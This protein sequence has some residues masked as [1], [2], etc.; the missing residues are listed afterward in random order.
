MRE[1]RFY[2][3]DCHVEFKVIVEPDHSEEDI[4]T[5]YPEALFWLKKFSECPV[6]GG[7]LE[8]VD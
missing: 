7:K 1:K 2:C 5:N 8:E 3:P 4:G 6:C